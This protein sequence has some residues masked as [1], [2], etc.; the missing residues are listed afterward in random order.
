[1]PEKSDEPPKFN[2]LEALG[3]E[4]GKREKDLAK[5]KPDDENG[6]KSLKSGP[7]SGP[8]SRPKS[9]PTTDL[10]G[11][12]TDGADASAG[13]A[14]ARQAV[15]HGA[16]VSPED[17]L[18]SLTGLRDWLEHELFEG[19]G[20]V[21]IALNRI[22]DKHTHETRE[23]WSNSAKGIVRWVVIIAIVALLVN[24]LSVHSVTGA[25][26]AWAQTVW[27]WLQGFGINTR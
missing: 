22:V 5:G 13:D 9:A 12:S 14:S 20:D 15:G 3:K 4:I 26:P 16:K 21:L 11:E 1:M 7:K 27:A 19:R 17:V 6:R 10:E 8:H 24:I 25:L 2:V 23:K 18:R